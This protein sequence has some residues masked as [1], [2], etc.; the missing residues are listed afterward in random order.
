MT[1]NGEAVDLINSNLSTGVD[2]TAALTLRENHGIS[3]MGDTKVG[4]FDLSGEEA[5]QMLLLPTNVN[6]KPNSDVVVPWV[7]GM[8]LTRRS[9]DMFII[10]FGLDTPEAD[11]AAYEAPFE[12]V[13]AHVYPQRS[14]N[15]REAY[16]ERWWLHAEPRP[17][18][19]KL[20]ASLSR[21]IVTP[22]LSKHRVFAWLA[23]PTLPDH[24]LIAIARDDDYAFGVLHSR[25]HELWSL[26][27]GTSLEDR[28]RYTPTTTF[29]TFPFPWPLNTPDEALT[30]KQRRHR[31]AIGGA[32]R[33]LDEKRRLWLNPPE[34]VREEPDVI[35]SLPPR[36]LPVN[37]HAEQQLNERTLNDL[38]N[39]RPTWLD[40]LHANLDAAVC[41][42]YGWPTD[43]GDEA[44][45]ERLLSLNLKRAI[46]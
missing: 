46:D 31:D 28:P 32:A 43:I 42:A 12:Y 15:R 40:N 19:R 38:Y 35:L 30:P 21:C 1:L 39:E 23:A 5:R 34:W 24:Q 25:V 3:L 9:R 22:T 20:I 33:E 27:M 10:D 36:L 29:E 6:G 8:D 13:L 11:A 45:L 14:K 16:R 44:I 26:R 17:A 4:P 41:V 18:L 37:E 7:N 2:L